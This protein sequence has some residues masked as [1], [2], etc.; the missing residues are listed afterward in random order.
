MK[1]SKNTQHKIHS[2]VFTMKLQMFLYIRER[3]KQF[4]QHNFYSLALAI[5]GFPLSNHRT[6]KA[7]KFSATLPMLYFIFRDA[8]QNLLTEQQSI[9][10][11]LPKITD[12]SFARC[13]Q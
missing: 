5:T 7:D 2:A 10:E 8:I 6:R 13:Y 9:D 11:I 3:E 4:L 1:N 12:Q